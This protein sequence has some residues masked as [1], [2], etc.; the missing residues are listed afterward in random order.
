MA[1]FHANSYL[2]TGRLWSTLRFFLLVFKADVYSYGAG[3]RRA[4][5]LDF[6]ALRMYMTAGA[7]ASSGLL[8]F[9][10]GLGFIC[11]AAPDA[12]VSGVF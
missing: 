12:D 1:D 5:L 2:L 8:V 11:D 4:G 10:I 6:L 7:L 9:C 3:L